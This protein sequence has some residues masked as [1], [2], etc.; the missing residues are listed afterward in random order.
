M[1]R[2]SLR[3]LVQPL[4]EPADPAATLFGLRNGF[5]SLS[6]GRGSYFRLRFFE[7]DRYSSWRSTRSGNAGEDFDGFGRA[8]TLRPVNRVETEIVAF[9]WIGAGVDEQPDDIGVTANNRENERGLA[10]ARL[11]VY[12]RAIG[13]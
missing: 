11:L 3:L 9:V 8:S 12:V 10:A 5:A 13:Q 2:V 7:V 4:L 6:C 1:A